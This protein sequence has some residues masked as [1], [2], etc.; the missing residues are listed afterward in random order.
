MYGIYMHSYKYECIIDEKN[1]EY[2]GEFFLIWVHGYSWT[3][4]LYVYR[5]SETFDGQENAQFLELKQI[6][7]YR[8]TVVSKKR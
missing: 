3:M 5:N 8:S 6:V 4:L 2:F 1:L 7:A